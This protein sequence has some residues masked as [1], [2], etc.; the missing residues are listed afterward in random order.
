MFS[1]VLQRTE[2]VKKVLVL[3]PGRNRSNRRRIADLLKR[4][5]FHLEICPRVDLS[6]FDIDV[7]EE[8][9]NHVERDSA[10]QQVH[11]FRVAKRMRT[12]R[13]VQ[14]RKF[15]SC[16]RRDTFEE[17]S[18][19]PN[20]IVVDGVRC[21]KEA[22]QTV[23]D[24]RDGFPVCGRAEAGPSCPSKV[25]RASC[26]P[27]P[28]DAAARVDPIARLQPKDRS[29]PEHA[30][31]CRR[32]RSAKQHLFDL[33]EFSGPAAPESQPGL[34]SKG[35]RPLDEHAAAGE[36]RG[37]FGTEAC[38]R[39]PRPEHIGRMRAESQADGFAYGA[40]DFLSVSK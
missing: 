13:S 8:I 17:C 34:P 31:R 29:T 27:F 22:C 25:Q 18:G 19:F 1:D 6:C 32:G 39:A 7:T 26:V 14:T 12:H 15:A 11:S 40:T 3:L 20:E 24:D 21:G 5:S 36:S 23:R 4:V 10:L 28:E 35:I 16:S 33:L 38:G 2:P 30:L 9:P 37:F